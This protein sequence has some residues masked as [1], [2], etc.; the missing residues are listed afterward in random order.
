MKAKNKVS[1][2]DDNVKLQYTV[3][4]KFVN[5]IE[6]HQ[7]FLPG[8]RQTG[9]VEMKDV[10]ATKKSKSK[11]TYKN[12]NQSSSSV[13]EY[14]LPLPMKYRNYKM[15]GTRVAIGPSRIHRNGLF[16]MDNFQPGE[17][18]I[19]YVGEVITNKIADFREKEYNLRG[20][21]DCYMF[22]VD[23]D[24]IIDATKYGNLARSINHSCDPN[25]TAQSNEI[26][27]RKHI[28]LYAKKYIKL[29]EEITYDYNFESETEKIQCR[30]GAP[31]CQ[32]R[33]N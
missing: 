33:L 11:Q 28:L 6:S 5:Y 26:N 32:G 24:K 14:N 18:V 31:N 19:E 8:R 3:C 22:R 1:D 13:I 30:C 27:G 20:F 17:I 15:Q 12:L 9:D 2:I 23:A 29:G 7:Q 16:A 21:G 25:C 4:F 10:N